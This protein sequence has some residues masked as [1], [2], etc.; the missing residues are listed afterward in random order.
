MPLD[1]FQKD[2]VS[3]IRA[4]RD[5][6]SPFARGS[7]IQHHGFRLSEDQDIFAAGDLDVLM[8]RD[9]LSLEAAGFSVK[10]IESNSLYRECRIT[11]PMEGR[12]T[13][14]WTHGLNREFYEPVLDHTF[15]YRLH[16]VDLAVNKSLAAGGRM[17]KRDFVDLWMLDR[18]VMPLW[19]ITC[20]APGKYPRRNPFS[21]LE[22]ISKNYS[23]T[24]QMPEQS[25]RVLV[26][27]NHALDDM[28]SGMHGIINE[29]LLTL[30]KIPPE[31]YG[32]LQVDGDGQP[33]LSREPAFGGRWTAPRTGGCMPSFEGI[34]SEMIAGLIEEFG[35]EG[36]KFTSGP[37]AGSEFDPF[38]AHDELGFPDPF[39]P[40][41]PF[42]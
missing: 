29:A 32:R 42:E 37:A 9:T 40:P 10:L 38:D 16:F 28:Y 33:M 12:T 26:T 2:I 25:G 36:S 17:Q 4:N 8:Q 3:A 18:F 30:R 6:N 23:F 27:D 11:K 14:Q 24:M 34:D 35:P 39:D 20:A 21:L 1:D 22:H 5:F 31:C 19:R 13:L 7:V 41:S 15:G